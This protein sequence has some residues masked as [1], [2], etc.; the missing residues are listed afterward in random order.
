MKQ[1]TITLP[2]EV[3]EYIN[4]YSQIMEIMHYHLCVLILTQWVEAHKRED[5][6]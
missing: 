1:L 5:E 2:D 3:Y 6:S 4:E